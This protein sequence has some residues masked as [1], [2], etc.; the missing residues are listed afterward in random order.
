MEEIKT[1]IT[2]G[3]AKEFY[4]KDPKANKRE[5]AEKLLTETNLW[6]IEERF[7]ETEKQAFENATEA[8]RN[9]LRHLISKGV[10]KKWR[11]IDME[12]TLFNLMVILFY[13]YH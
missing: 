11:G 8:V 5:T 12:A 6:I 1:V 13:P 9:N 3:E 2:V 4:L 7:T 10:S